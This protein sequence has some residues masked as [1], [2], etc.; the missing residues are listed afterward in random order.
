MRIAL[1]KVLLERPDVMLLDE[2]TNYLDLEARTWLS[3]QLG[4]FNGGVLMVS[5]DRGFL[6]GTVNEV[7]ELFLGR[8]KTWKGNY[9]RYEASRAMEMEQ[10][11]KQ[12]EQ[13]QQEIAQLED[14]IRRFRA[15][16]SK[17]SQVQSRV[18]QLEK[19]IPIEIPEGLKRMNVRFPEAPRSGDMV[20]SASDLEKSYGELHIFRNL[21]IELTRGERT[22]VL[23]PN[24]AGKSTLLRVL[25][26]RD[27]NYTGEVRLGSKVAQA[28]FAQESEDELD[29]TQTVIGEIETAAPTALIP[30]CGIFSEHSC[31]GGRISTSRSQSSA[32]A[33]RIAWPW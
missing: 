25:A 33:R 15:N 28:Y 7:A 14:F 6:D 23:G 26:G 5:H 1:A 24:G 32:G 16:A 27:R 18:K 21:D 11:L 30:S 10:L 9:S 12:Y 8:L 4:R 22:V 31:S 2:P 29:M 19:I 20:L 3:D 17:A 13:Q